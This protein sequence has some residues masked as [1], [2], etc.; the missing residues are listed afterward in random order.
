MG[1]MGGQEEEGYCFDTI[2][3]TLLQLP[4]DFVVDTTGVIGDEGQWDAYL[5]DQDDDDDIVPY[6]H[7]R[8]G[9][10]NRYLCTD[11]LRTYTY[12]P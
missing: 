5:T 2:N 1:G 7:T 6:I 12:L 3:P 9:I 10:L 8:P 11:I 4:G